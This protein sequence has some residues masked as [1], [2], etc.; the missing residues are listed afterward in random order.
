MSKNKIIG[1]AV[2]AVIVVLA[3]V[4]A[5]VK[6]PPGGIS[7]P[8]D[9]NGNETAP[10]SFVT[11]EAAPQ[12]IVVPSQNATSVPQN[13]AV[14]EIVSPAAVGASENLRNFTVKAENGKFAPDTVIVRFGDVVNISFAAIDKDYDLYQPDYGFRAAAAKGGAAKIQFGATASGK[15]TFYCPSCGGPESGPIGYIIVAQQ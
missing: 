1:I 5:L 8:S 15:F 14:P 6:S 2:A 3:I 10:K 4:F 7:A 11:R 12:N 13:V 9:N